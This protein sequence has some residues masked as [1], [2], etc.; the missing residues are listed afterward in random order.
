M[1]LL[2]VGAR[3]D[4]QAHVVLEVIQSD[5]THQAV[6]FAD[7]TPELKGQQVLGRPV[8]GDPAEVAEQ[9]AELGITGAFIAV[10]APQ[11]RARLAKICQAMGLSLPTLIHPTAYLSPEA[12][13]GEGAFLGAGVQVLPGASVGDLC[14]V[15]A[16]TIVSHHVRV[17]Y[18]NT[19]GPNATLAGR[20]S[21]ESFV[22]LGAGCTLLPEVK[23]GARTTVGAGAV[24]THNVPPDLT[25]VGVP[26]RPL[27]CGSRQ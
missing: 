7:E 17:G 15:N 6:A 8:L 24:V 25:V 3:T 26:A 4:G 18:C 14:R 12:K 2:I 10:G 11:P 23:V 1:K 16:G 22:F 9:V 19:I 27:D 21:T 5:D 13:I 20:S